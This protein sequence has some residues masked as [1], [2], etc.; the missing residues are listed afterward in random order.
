M[1]YFI[2]SGKTSLLILR[3]HLKASDN[4]IAPLFEF[5]AVTKVTGLTASGDV[6]ACVRLAGK[7]LLTVMA[8]SCCEEL[9]REIFLHTQSTADISYRLDTLVKPC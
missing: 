5:N 8:E 4:V 3:T 1:N 2:E 7:H 6:C 9:S